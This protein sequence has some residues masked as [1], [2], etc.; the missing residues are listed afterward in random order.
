MFRSPV[1]PP[2]ALAL[3]AVPLV[4]ACV[5][6]APSGDARLV[7]VTSTASE[8]SLSTASAPS[9]TL[10]F[11][12]TNGGSDITEFYLLGADGSK[13]VGEVEDIGPGLTRDTVV[14]AP[15]GSYVTACKPGMTGDGIRAPFTVTDSGTSIA[16]ASGTAEPEESDAS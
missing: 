14:Q 11:R 6:N 8:C 9:G 15:A 16:P 12:V 10:T 2:V 7:T 13:V 4:A 5:S 1:T 3:L